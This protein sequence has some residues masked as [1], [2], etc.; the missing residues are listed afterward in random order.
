MLKVA[1]D[2]ARLLDDAIMAYPVAKPGDEYS[3][4]QRA[5]LRGEVYHELCAAFAK[6]SVPLPPLEPE[7][8]ET[9]LKTATDTD[10]IAEGDRLVKHINKQVKGA[11]G[12]FNASLGFMVAVIET[13]R[14]I[15]EWN[16]LDKEYS[17]AKI[18]QEL[19]MSGLEPYRPDYS[20]MKFGVAR[21]MP[22]PSRPVRVVIV[23]DD[24]QEIVK[25]ARRLAGWPEIEFGW[26]L[27]H[28]SLAERALPKKFE[29]MAGLVEVIFA[30]KPDVVLMDEGID[31]DFKGSDLVKFVMADT[32]NTTVFVANTGG[33]DADLR[34]AGAFPNCNKGERPKAVAS[35]L[36]HAG[37]VP[38]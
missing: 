23:D 34:R 14:V 11:P 6:A 36:D 15:F 19:V 16:G 26:A 2:L 25:T 30:T 27:Y 32:S 4:K 12:G 1:S 8:Y 28:R 20:T 37:L 13:F 38:A 5:V 24:V 29:R 10:A 9:V 7:F 31:N 17:I 22:T 21:D 33:D 35:A 18:N 3:M